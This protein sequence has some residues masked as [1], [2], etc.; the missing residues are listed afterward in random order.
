MGP[1][2]S[3]NNLKCFEGHH[4]LLSQQE[5]YQQIYENNHK[6]INH[7]A[8]AQSIAKILATN[9]ERKTKKLKINI[10]QQI[11]LSLFDVA[12]NM[13]KQCNRNLHCHQ[14]G[15][16]K[17]VEIKRKQKIRNLYGKQDLVM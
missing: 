5:I 14:N 16:N 15:N 6:L 17:Y 13:R 9:R 11:I 3:T 8:T 7:E 4:L 2:E 10:F 12:A 1:K